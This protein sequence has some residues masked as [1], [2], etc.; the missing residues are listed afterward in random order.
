M[1]RAT[2]GAEAIPKCKR[3]SA[4]KACLPSNQAYEWK[5]S[6]ALSI[7]FGACDEEEEGLEFDGERI[8]VGES[9]KYAMSDI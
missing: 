4:K 9:R 5:V 2:D 3:A 7:G 1:T 6:Q 8:G